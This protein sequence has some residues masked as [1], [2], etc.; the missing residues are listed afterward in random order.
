MIAGTDDGGRIHDHGIQSTVDG[1]IDLRLG[2]AFA[3]GVGPSGAEGIELCILVGGGI[4]AH[5]DGGY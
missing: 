3:I 4:L 2:A 5:A 1:P